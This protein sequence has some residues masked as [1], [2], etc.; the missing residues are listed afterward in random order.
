MKFRKL[1]RTGLDVSLICLGTM[2][3]GQQNTEEEAFAQMDYA[4]A[5]GINFFDTAELYSIP[6]KPE[7]QG[8]CEARHEGRVGSPPTGVPDGDH[9]ELRYHGPLRRPAHGVIPARLVPVEGARHP[10]VPHG[11]PRVG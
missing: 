3:W 7:T 4:V 9:A 5:Q 6:P 1:G 11:R 8:S 2:T 10:G